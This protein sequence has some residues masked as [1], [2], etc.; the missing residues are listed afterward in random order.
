MRQWQ[1]EKS[2]VWLPGFFLEPFTK[3][4]IQEEKSCGLKYFEYKTW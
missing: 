3:E 1:E 4:E 2:Q